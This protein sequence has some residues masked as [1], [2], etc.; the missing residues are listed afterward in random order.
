M[1]PP[2]KKT[3]DSSKLLIGAVI[4]G[5]LG[6][7]SSYAEKKFSASS[8]R[9]LATLRTQLLYPGG[10]TNHVD[11]TTLAGYQSVYVVTQ[12]ADMTHNQTVRDYQKTSVAYNAN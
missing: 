3:K 12:I 4:G 1:A 2:K 5:G 7:L 11:N 9:D 6:A 8:S 10:M